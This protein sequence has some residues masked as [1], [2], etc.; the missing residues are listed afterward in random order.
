MIRSV[1]QLKIGPSLQCLR[2]QVRVRIAPFRSSRA[3]FLGRAAFWPVSSSVSVQFTGEGGDC[4]G[5]L[6]FRLLVPLVR[7]LS[8]FRLSLV[9]FS[10]FFVLRLFLM[11]C[12]LT[13]FM[14]VRRR[15]FNWSVFKNV[16]FLIA[17]TMTVLP[18]WFLMPNRRLWWW[19]RT[20]PVLVTARVLW[21]TVLPVLTDRW[22][23]GRRGG[24]I[25]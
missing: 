5:G 6:F 7:R 12:F 15:K 10:P 4:V 23:R 13:W 1:L 16:V 8:W 25:S 20:V 21:P 22:C 11:L 9:L 3:A 2:G 19:C 14:R 17:V 18:S 24:V